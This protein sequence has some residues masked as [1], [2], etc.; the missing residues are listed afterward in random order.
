[1]ETLQKYRKKYLKH[2][3]KQKNEGP[4]NLS[5]M[6]LKVNETE[7]DQ[8]DFVQVQAGTGHTLLLNSLGQVVSFGEGLNG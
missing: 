3:D 8:F 5:E 6:Q 7:G 1:M 4:R 2:F